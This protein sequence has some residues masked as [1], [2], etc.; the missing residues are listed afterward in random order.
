MTQMKLSFLWLSLRRRK[1]GKK[2]YSYK[3]PS[4]YEK[5][6]QESNSDAYKVFIRLLNK[7]MELK[8]M[9]INEYLYRF[10]ADGNMR[11]TI[12]GSMRKKRLPPT[13]VIH[14]FPFLTEEEV[15]WLEWFSVNTTNGITRY[16]DREDY[17]ILIE[18]YLNKEE[19]FRP[20]IFLDCEEVEDEEV[21][22]KRNKPRRNASRRYYLER[23][24]ILG[25]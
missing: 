11:N 12:S 13:Y 3:L 10:V 22:I 17:K 20:D 25:V 1:M 5:N 15:T 24:W 16:K 6:L 19:P 14:K 7:D 23:A 21:M 18:K 4:W 9:C 8:D 2:A